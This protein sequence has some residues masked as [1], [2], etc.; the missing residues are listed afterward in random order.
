MFRYRLLISGMLMATL[1]SHP[2][3]AATTDDYITCSL[4]Y[5]AVFEAAKRTADD[6]LMQY[7][8]PRMQ[9]L[10]PYLQQNREDPNAKRRL[11]ELSIELEDEIRY[12]FV[13]QLTS[14]ILTQDRT[15][16]IITMPRVFQCD[17]VFGL[18]TLPF[19]LSKTKFPSNEYLEG[20]L[21]GCLKKQNSAARP[22]PDG[23]IQ[24]YCKCMTQAASNRGVDGSGTEAR[25]G[26]VIRETHPLCLASIQ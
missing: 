26:E 12:K 19:P 11:R 10:L 13:E 8:R 3:Q 24:T 18:S 9:A 1:F 7:A 21:A 23:K 4:V 22:L 5:G 17:R 14:A 2:S 25:L 20:F 6:A 15:R 16:L